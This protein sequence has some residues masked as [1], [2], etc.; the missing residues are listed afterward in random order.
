MKLHVCGVCATMFEDYGFVWY[1]EDMTT[2][3][4]ELCGPQPEFHGGF[5]VDRG[6]APGWEDAN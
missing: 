5:G 3:L 6:T 1:A 2:P 4:C